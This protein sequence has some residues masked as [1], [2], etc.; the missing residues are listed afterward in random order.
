MKRLK[1]DV[2]GR[3][4]ALIAG[5]PWLD[6]SLR[7]TPPHRSSAADRMLAVSQISRRG[8]GPS[9][10]HAPRHDE[11]GACRVSVPWLVHPGRR[12]PGRHA[13]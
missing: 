3:L 12:L 10:A 4:F 9:R 7:R 2:L 6:R 13:G 11:S 5:L 8:R 1:L